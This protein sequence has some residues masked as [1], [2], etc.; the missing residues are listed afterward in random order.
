MTMTRDDRVRYGRGFD[1]GRD[2]KPLRTETSESF[3]D[4]WRSGR[5]SLACERGRSAGL[6]ALQ[7]VPVVPEE[8]RE[9]ARSWEAGFESGWNSAHLRA[10]Y[11]E[12]RAA[13]DARD[14]ITHQMDHD[15]RSE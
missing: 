8:E 2:G 6:I 4:G 5:A 13:L 1:E 7:N 12:V 9:F 10:P 15:R 11:D 14:R 3:Q